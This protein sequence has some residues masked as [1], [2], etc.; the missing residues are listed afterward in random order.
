M[1]SAKMVSRISSRR[2]IYAAI[3]GDLLIGATKFVAAAATGSSAMFSEGV[4]SVVDTEGFC[5]STDCVGP[6][7]F[8]IPST[9]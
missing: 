6:Q 2:V 3:V 9:P 7:H 5:F 4:H 1:P 8:P